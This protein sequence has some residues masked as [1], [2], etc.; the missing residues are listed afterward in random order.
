MGEG[1]TESGG[2]LTDAVYRSMASA[3][4]IYGRKRCST[5]ANPMYPSSLPHLRAAAASGDGNPKSPASFPYLR[6]TAFGEWEPEVHGQS[7]AFA[8]DRLRQI[9][10]VSCEPLSAFVDSESVA[11]IPRDSEY[12]CSTGGHASVCPS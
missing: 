2:N 8:S 6:A 4:R 10:A 7:L 9:P 1:K 5:I 3:L 12:F 11:V